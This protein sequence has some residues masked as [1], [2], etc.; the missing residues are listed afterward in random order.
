MEDVKKSVDTKPEGK[1]AKAETALEQRIRVLEEQLTKAEEAR[2][3]Q[4]KA[5]ANLRFDQQLSQE[6]DGASPLHKGIV[7]ELLANR[8]KADAVETE[9]S[10][11]VNGKTLAEVTKSFFETPE[12][13][14]FL[15]SSHQNG[16]GVTEAKPNKNA[17]TASLASELAAAFL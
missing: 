16:A 1:P 17:G 8:L 14:H 10:W 13:Q 6:L 5:S 11:L 2:Q 3:A 7:K 9:G 15:P 12:G 4:E